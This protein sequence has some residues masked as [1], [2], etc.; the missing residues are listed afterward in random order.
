MMAGRAIGFPLLPMTTSLLMPVTG[1]PRQVNVLFHEAVS[2][3]PTQTDSARPERGRRGRK[4]ASARKTGLRYLCPEC[5]VYF[6]KSTLKP[7]LMKHTGEAPF[8]CIYC[9]R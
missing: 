6:R 9:S 1:F 7:H 3:L 5:D 2:H 4:S 8:H